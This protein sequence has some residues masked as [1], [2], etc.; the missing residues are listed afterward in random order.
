MGGIALGSLQVFV[1]RF[2]PQAVFQFHVT[3]GGGGP[4]SF[5]IQS[6]GSGTIAVASGTFI[7]PSR[8]FFWDE[9][10]A[11]N[12]IAGSLPPY[13]K[14]YQI[15]AGTNIVMTNDNVWV[16]LSTFPF[17]AVFAT[18]ALG[19]ATIEMR[20]RLKNF[21]GAGDPIAVQ[22]YSVEVVA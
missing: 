3:D 5:A 10:Q 18:G 17:D 14:N 2:T 11:G 12:I 20:V 1:P 15:V 22:Q 4:G 9:P 21:T 8:T 7:G 16:D 13:Q 19:F 6:S